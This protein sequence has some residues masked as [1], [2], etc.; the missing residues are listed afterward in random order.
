[1]H[2]FIPALAS[3]Y[4]ASICEIPISNPKREF[5]KSH[6]GISR[7]FRVFFD[8]LTIRF[9]LKYMTRP[10][11]FFGTIGALSVLAGAGMSVWLLALKLMTGQHVMDLHG[12]L[13]VV[14]GIFI[15]AGVQMIGIGLLGEL[16]VRHFH[17][18]SH[19]A[20]YAIDRILR[21]RSEESLLQ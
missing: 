9:L 14:A 12:P 17:T 11:H 13:F 5:G 3:W 7:T 10:L 21:L 1:M 8:L 19:R 20:P 15:L 18:A 6:Y 4:G 2:R 16:Q